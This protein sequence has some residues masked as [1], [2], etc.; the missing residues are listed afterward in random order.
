[1]ASIGELVKY[2]NS[3]KQEVCPTWPLRVRQSAHDYNTKS[4]KVEI[5]L[6]KIHIKHRKCPSTESIFHFVV[7]VVVVGVGGIY[8]KSSFTISA[9]LF[10]TLFSQKSFFEGI[11]GRG[12]LKCLSRGIF[13]PTPLLT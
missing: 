8:R 13:G 5:V 10:G 11:L 12:L 9:Y 4:R 2:W 3:I 1:M 6:I 7:V